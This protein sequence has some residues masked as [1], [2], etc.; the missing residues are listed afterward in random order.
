MRPLN[1]AYVWMVCVTRLG[2]SSN[3]L[4]FHPVALNRGI[5]CAGVKNIVSSTIKYNLL[6]LHPFLHFERIYLTSF[7]MRVIGAYC[8]VQSQS[9]WTTSITRL[10]LYTCCRTN[11]LNHKE[12]KS[13]R[14]SYY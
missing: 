1:V 13:K 11:I 12:R 14:D 7:G 3:L 6:F 5:M 2:S 9:A 8:R 10:V 4:R